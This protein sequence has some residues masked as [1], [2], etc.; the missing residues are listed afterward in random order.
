MEIKEDI[1]EGWQVKYL[2]LNNTMRL[3]IIW[4]LLSN[5][6]YSQL[7]EDI[8]ES[9]D[10]IGFRW[11]EKFSSCDIFLMGATNRFYQ[12][13]NNHLFQDAVTG[14]YLIDSNK[15]T[16]FCD[17][18]CNGRIGSFTPIVIERTI[19]TVGNVVEINSISNQNIDQYREEFVQED[20][21]SIFKLW[22]GNQLILSYSI[23][24]KTSNYFQ[25]VMPFTIEN[26]YSNEGI[27]GVINGDLNLE[28]EGK[29]FKRFHIKYEQPLTKQQLRRLKCS[30]KRIERA[31]RKYRKKYG[32]DEYVN[33]DT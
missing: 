29:T 21:L 24:N 25:I 26:L 1:K 33:Y 22:D 20:S 3:I 31:N 32:T 28:L 11:S 15:V 18:N 16:F 9:K 4:V 2:F 19:D 30:K 8:F 6:L 13:F 12:G 7:K 14:Y 10:T 17:S 23:K 27:T 5:C